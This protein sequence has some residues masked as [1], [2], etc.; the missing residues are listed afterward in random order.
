MLGQ[1]LKRLAVRADTAACLLHM[2][3]ASNTG[4]Q[5][6]AGKVAIVTASTE[7]IGLGIAKR[8]CEDGAKVMVS[9][10]K[11]EKVDAAVQQLRSE[12]LQASG[13]VC[14]VSDAAHR[15]KLIEET[16]KQFG[17][18]DIL[19]SNAGV[20]PYFGPLLSTPEDAWDKIFDTNVK[21]GFML[22]KE[23]APHL[24]KRGGGSIVFV[25][26]IAAY[27]PVALIGAYS[28]SKTAV[29]G[30]VKALAPELAGGNIR[31]NGVAPGIIK[32]GFSAALW[33][34]E[35]IADASLQQIPLR[36]FG[37][38]EDVAGVVSF[39]ASEDSSYL[40]GETILAAGGM[41]GRL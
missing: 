25:S 4:G 23:I 33:G 20:S 31:I 12:N 37:T 16:M 29:L 32:T 21:S 35:Q 40:T 22:C 14:H 34:N 30:M 39:L 9:S 17:G 18:V 1:G 36:R 11:K 38:P 5:K 6:L 13:I 19:V 28:I 10:R 2:R 41:I 15:T 26:S 8:L 7:G 3:M 24:E 27:S